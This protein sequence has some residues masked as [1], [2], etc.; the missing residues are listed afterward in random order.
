MKKISSATPSTRQPLLRRWPIAALLLQAISAGA[1]AQSAPDAGRL[2]QEIKPAPTLPKSGEAALPAAAPERPALTLPS[3]TMIQVSAIDISGAAAI[4]AA[5]LQPLV[6]G[7]V[8]GRHSLAELEQGAQRISAYYRGRGYLLARAYLPA[9]DIQDGKVEMR[10]LEGRLNQLKLDN[11][12][13]IGDAWVGAR[14]NDVKAGEALQ[15]DTLESSL[16]RLSDTPGLEVRSSLKPGASVGTTDLDIQ[17]RD[18]RQV[19]GGFGVDNY[20]NRYTGQYRLGGNVTVN[21]P[22]GLG[23]ALQISGVS[24]GK[25]FNYGRI[26]Y[27]LPVHRSGTRLGVSYAGM[28][29]ELGKDF[30]QLD[31][32]GKARIGSVF[33]TQPLVRRR[34]WSLNGQL[35][36]EHKQLNDVIGATATR[37]NKQYNNVTL[38]LS[39]EARD[40]VNGGG[41]TQASFSLTR[42]NLGMDAGSAALDALGH[43]TQGQFLKFN[44][45]VMRLQ[46]LNDRFSL[47]TQFSAQVANGNLDSAE[48]MD[49][50]GAYGVRAYPQGEAAADDAWLGNAELRYSLSDQW[51]ALTFFDA[52]QGHLNHDPIAGDGANR[53]TL[54]GFGAGF[55]WSNP[56]GYSLQGTAA[57]RTSGEPTSDRDRT[58]RLNLQFGRQF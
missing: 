2:L 20:G 33:L 7:L 52:A 10:V 31:A 55:R 18:G 12:S 13:R 34:A 58:P 28:H 38:G 21:N 50:G 15:S 51:Q 48:K 42:G 25:D 39:G 6:A 23:D 5:E 26:S 3:S 44:P 30:D 36:L 49:L 47:Y 16:L 41:L 1:Y 14:L 46:R 37:V 11:K 27:Q 17:V 45:Q 29:Y 8:G 22:F 54:A 56:Q 43:A 32:Y 53:R 40:S 4:P 19:E 9:Q 57:W 24:G 35:S